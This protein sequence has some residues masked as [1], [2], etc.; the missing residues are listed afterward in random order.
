MMAHVNATEAAGLGHPWDTRGQHN[1]ES[2]EVTT[3]GEHVVV[4]PESK[5]SYT[6]CSLGTNK[7]CMKER[8]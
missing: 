1:T 4:D 7:S 6:V 5:S 3:P 8:V 2:N